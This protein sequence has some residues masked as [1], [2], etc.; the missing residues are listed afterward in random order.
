MVSGARH[1]TRQKLNDENWSGYYSYHKMQNGRKVYKASL[2]LTKLF[3]HK[4]VFRR[5]NNLRM[6]ST[7]IFRTIKKEADGD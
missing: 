2:V 6:D 7:F 4:F 1:K 5:I 3:V